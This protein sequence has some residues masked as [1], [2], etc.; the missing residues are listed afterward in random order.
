MI[1]TRPAGASPVDTVAGQAPSPDPG[2]IKRVIIGSLS[3]GALLMLV[4]TVGVAAG[5]REHVVTAMALLGG[6]HR[7][8][9]APSR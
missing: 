5:A 8:P 6:R 3:A 9:G 2:P 1:I 7:P 4:L